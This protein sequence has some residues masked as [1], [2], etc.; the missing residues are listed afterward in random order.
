MC[1][2]GPSRYYRYSDQQKLQKCLFWG[3]Y[4]L[5]PITFVRNNERN[6]QLLSRNLCWRNDTLIIFTVFN[7]YET[8][9]II[10]IVQTFL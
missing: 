10:L 4:I 6:T 3:V 9:F 5:E 1:W 8:V 7:L 2:V